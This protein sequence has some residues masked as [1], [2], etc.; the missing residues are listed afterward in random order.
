MAHIKYSTTLVDLSDQLVMIAAETSVTGK[1][2]MADALM[3]TAARYK[4][5]TLVIGDEDFKD[6]EKVVYIGDQ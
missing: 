2:P 6:M 4:R 5:A 1:I 3:Y